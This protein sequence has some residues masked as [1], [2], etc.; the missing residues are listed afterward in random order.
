MLKLSREAWDGRSVF[1]QVEEQ[2]Y[3]FIK[4]GNR[5]YNVQLVAD[6]L[7]KYGLKKPA[8]QKALEALADGGKITCKVTLLTPMNA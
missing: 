2:V 4:Q 1:S 7:A 6:N 8:I 5:P 3:Q